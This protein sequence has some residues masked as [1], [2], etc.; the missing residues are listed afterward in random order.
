M[1]L[2]GKARQ[3]KEVHGGQCH[4]DGFTGQVVHGECG[5]VALCYPLAFSGLFLP[6][7][8]VACPF[9]LSTFQGT[10]EAVRIN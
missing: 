4:H 3:R 6:F 10:F 2:T 8:G 9:Y 1:F 5:R 7:D